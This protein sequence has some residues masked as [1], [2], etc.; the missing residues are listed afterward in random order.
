[1][2]KLLIINLSPRQKGTSIVLAEMCKKYMEDR[3]HNIELLH[4]YPNLN[5]PDNLCEAVKAADT[6]IFTGPSYIN[7]YPAD[8]FALLEI[9]SGQKE[10]LHGQDLYGMIQGGMPYVHTHE[11]G[12]LSL[13]IFGKKCNVHYKGGFVMGM[14]AMLDGRPVAKLINGRKVI[15]QLNVFFENIE[16]GK[17]SPNHVY[18]LA[19]LNF[20]GF[21]YRIMAKMANKAMDKELKKRGI[22]V[23][24]PG[25][26]MKK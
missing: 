9:L 14:G 19:Q 26:Y 5:N 10:V 13:K 8:T 4:L 18:Q 15:R 20:P 3:G 21:V 7:T 17:V 16:K 2:K 23:N 22:D 24:Q 11:S 25:S 6:L 12:L 1:M